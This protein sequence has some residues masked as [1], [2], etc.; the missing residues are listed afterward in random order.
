MTAQ[1]P[2]QHY[3]YYCGD[4]DLS[5]E[6]SQVTFGHLHPTLEVEGDIIVVTISLA[7]TETNLL[8]VR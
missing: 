5:V 6:A 3:K 7:I 2:C 1:L 8:E 4:N